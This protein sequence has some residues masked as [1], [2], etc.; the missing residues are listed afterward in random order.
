MTVYVKE[1]VSWP[2]MVKQCQSSRTVVPVK[3]D[4]SFVT[5]G[6]NWTL[7]CLCLCNVG[8]ISSLFKQLGNFKLY[9]QWWWITLELKTYA[10]TVSSRTHQVFKANLEAGSNCQ[11]SCSLTHYTILT[12][13]EWCNFFLH[14]DI[15]RLLVAISLS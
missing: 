8:T 10:Y 15:N 9:I 13:V 11:H 3:V 5:S 4:K 7:Y 1:T 6:Y 12:T 2:W 14:Q